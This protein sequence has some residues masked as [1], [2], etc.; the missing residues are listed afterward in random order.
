MVKR[1]KKVLINNKNKKINF[2]NNKFNNKKIN[3]VLFLMSHVW[4]KI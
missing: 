4:M 1:T 3:Q 2:S